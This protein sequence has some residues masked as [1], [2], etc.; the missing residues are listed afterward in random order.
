MPSSVGATTVTR[1]QMTASTTALKSVGG[2]GVALS[3]ADVPFKR[4]SKVSAGPGRRGQT[5]PVCTKESDRT[6]VDPVHRKNLK[7]SV[8]K[9]GIICILEVQEYLEYDRLPHGRMLLKQLGLE[10]S[11]PRPTARPKPVQ[12]IAKIDGCCE[13]AVQ[14]A[15]DSLPKY[16]D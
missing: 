16:L 3:H 6:G 10:G 12:H 15:R 13:L 8:P 1:W 14:K 5:V 4:Y 9:Q 11:G 7:A 2:Q